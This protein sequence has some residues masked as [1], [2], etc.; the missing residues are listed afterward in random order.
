M[1]VD[2][3]PRMH[4]LV[5]AF[6]VLFKQS[7]GFW[8]RDPQNGLLGLLCSGTIPFNREVEA[9]GLYMYTRAILFKIE[10]LY[11]LHI[12]EYFYNTYIH[13]IMREH[14]QMYMKK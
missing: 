4:S 10:F 3:A 14:L 1:G 8:L 7:Q 5:C 2:Q 11:F 6:D 13:E 12:G 9:E